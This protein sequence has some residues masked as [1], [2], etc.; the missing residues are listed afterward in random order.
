MRNKLPL[1]IW[2]TRISARTTLTTGF[3]LCC[4]LL[5]SSCVDA[6]VT[7]DSTFSPYASHGIVRRF[8]PVINELL[9]RKGHTQTRAFQRW[10]AL[11]QLYD[12]DTRAYVQ[13]YD[14]D[15]K[16]LDSAQNDQIYQVALKTMTRHV[17]SIKLPVLKVEASNLEQQLSQQ[18]GTWGLAHTFHDSY[19]GRTYQLGYEYGSNGIGGWLQSEIAHARTLAGYQQAIEDA[20]AFLTSFRAYQS[21]TLD[22][23]PWN[24]AHQTDLQLLRN[25]NDMQQIVIVVSLGEQVLRVYEQ[26]QLLR[27]FL[28]TTGRPEKPSLP[29]NWVVEA[30]RSPTVFKSSESRSSP[31]WYPNTPINYALLYHSDGYYI[32][33]SWW[34][35]DY[36]PNTQFP[37]V[38]SSG[39]TFS[40]DGSHGC[41]NIATSAAAWIYNSVAVNT[42]L[43]IY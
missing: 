30:K 7:S 33:D 26:G 24:K 18:A 41:V 17:A 28:V 40:F 10:I 29:G 2:Q 31:Y 13:E 11:M 4:L 6:N 14:S 5:L 27:A 34:R 36:G 43:L 19:N 23:T 22:K 21:N 37:H 8:V 25:Y 3:L 12:G 1:F 16:A 39:D 20:N 9:V 32:H 42:P 15:R 35:A 38:D